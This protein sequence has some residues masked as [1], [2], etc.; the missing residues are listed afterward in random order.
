MGDGREHMFYNLLIQHEVVVL[1]VVDCSRLGVQVSI[2]FK[3][4]FW[5]KKNVNKSYSILDNQIYSVYL[6]RN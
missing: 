2:V 5:M 3:I 1:V 6:M 4:K